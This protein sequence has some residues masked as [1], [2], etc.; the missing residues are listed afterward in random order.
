MS[1]YELIHASVKRGL[2]GGEGFGVAA[3][4]AGIPPELEAALCELSAYDFDAARSTGADPIEWA[5]RIVKTGGIHPYTVL[6]RIGPCGTDHSGRPNRVAHHIVLD[7]QSRVPTGPAWVLANHAFEASVPEVAERSSS[8]VIARPMAAPS[9]A[10]LAAGLKAAQI[11][12]GWAG[13]VARAVLDSPTSRIYLVFDRELELVPFML[14][15]ASL[16][17]ERNRWS[18][19][20][21]TRFQSS[22]VSLSCQVRC[23]RRGVSGTT[24]L[25]AERDIVRFDVRGEPKGLEAAIRAGREGHMLQEQQAAPA[26]KPTPSF[27]PPQPQPKAAPSQPTQPSPPAKPPEPPVERQARSVAPF[28]VE[29]E[30]APPAS[31]SRAATAPSHSPPRSTPSARPAARAGRESQQ[32]F[33]AQL[34]ETFGEGARWTDPLVM[35]LIFWALICLALSAFLLLNLFGGAA[36]A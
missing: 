9:S 33:G 23:V 20:F 16:L 11:D 36:T 19:T 14:Y 7:A 29:P 4:T 18:F 35:G 8:P 22:S 31:A 25:L 26:P 27:S 13:L 32:G 30:P 15:V 24:S 28:G 1:N 17:P 21:S 6:S 10:A 34:F 12:P 2:R 5:H 3:R